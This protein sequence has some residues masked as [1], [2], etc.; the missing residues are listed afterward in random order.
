MFFLRKSCPNGIMWKNVV[1]PCRLQKNRW[2]MR[3]FILD[4]WS[5][6]HTLIICNTFC[7]STA[8]QV[9]RRRHNVTLDVRCFSCCIPNK[10]YDEF[11]KVNYLKG[12]LLR[13][14]QTCIWKYGQVN[15]RYRSLLFIKEPSESGQVCT[16][17][18]VKWS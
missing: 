3:L 17:S 10:K 12:E 4:T 5:Y 14:I 18:Y 7:S 15:I 16:T 13:G 2:L 6:K 1:Q 8:K 9:V 11:R